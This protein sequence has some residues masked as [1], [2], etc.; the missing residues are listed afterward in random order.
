MVQFIVSLVKNK[1]Y[2]WPKLNRSTMSVIVDTITESAAPSNMVDLEGE[3]G[4]PGPTL[5]FD[6]KTLIL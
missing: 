1:G 5:T 3:P 4:E 2:S 6:P